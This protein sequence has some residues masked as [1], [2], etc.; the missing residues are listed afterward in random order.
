MLSVRAKFSIVAA[1]VVVIVGVLAA[2]ASVPTS[3]FVAVVVAPWSAPERV[4]AVVAAAGGALVAPA[5]VGWIVIAYSPRTDFI[6]QLRQSGA[7][8]V[9]NHKS[10]SGCF[11]RQ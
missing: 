2:A 7:W 6:F 1:N 11:P 5:R 3:S 4:A 9:L 8:F 10:L